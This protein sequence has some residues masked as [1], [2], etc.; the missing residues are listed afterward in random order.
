MLR[1]LIDEIRENYVSDPEVAPTREI[2]Y[3]PKATGIPLDALN[4]FVGA[5]TFNKEERDNINNVQSFGGLLLVDK[6]KVGDTI[7]YDGQTYKVTRH[8]KLG[9]QYIVYTEQSRQSRRGA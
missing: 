5:G 4:S 2:I 9:N 3:T 6:P 8:T 7:T 1:E